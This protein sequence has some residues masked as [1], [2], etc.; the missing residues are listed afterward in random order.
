MLTCEIKLV[1]DDFSTDKAEYR[2]RLMTDS[3]FQM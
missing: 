3:S 2:R 1:F